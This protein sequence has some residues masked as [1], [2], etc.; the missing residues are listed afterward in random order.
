MHYGCLSGAKEA[1]ELLFMSRSEVEILRD[2]QGQSPVYYV[3][4]ILSNILSDEILQGCNCF[5]KTS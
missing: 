4:T 5:L 2:L 3:S 1:I